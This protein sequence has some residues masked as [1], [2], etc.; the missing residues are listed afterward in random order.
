MTRRASLAAALAAAWLVVP[1]RAGAVCAPAAS[2]IFP[3]SGIAGTSVV[4]TISGSALDGGVLSVLGDP[5]LTATL[6]SSAP[7]TLTVR[8]DLDA[9]AT[10]GERLI[11]VDTPGGST[12][13]SFTINAAGGPVVDAVSPALIATQGVELDATVTGANLGG[14]TAGGVTVSGAGV[15]ALSATPSADGSTLSLAFGVDAAADL[16]T[17]AVTLAAPAGSA[18]LQLYVRRPPPT[19]TAILPAAGEVGATVPIRI[20]GTHLTDAA[21]VITTPG[22]T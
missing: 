16:G 10:P 12:G 14:V 1:A 21:L 13:V 7:A 17:H 11:F 3:A 4:A 19:V 9:T 5:G 20:T 2:G 15:S 6:Q 18:V 22:S 8:L